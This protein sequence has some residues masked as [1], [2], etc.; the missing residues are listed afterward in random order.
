MIYK[1]LTMKNNSKTINHLVKLLKLTN[2]L[3]CGRITLLILNYRYDQLNTDLIC[4]NSL[5]S[6]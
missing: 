4:M 6:E 1:G 3:I 2:K 5:V